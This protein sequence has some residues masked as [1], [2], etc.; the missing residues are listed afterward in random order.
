MEILKRTLKFLSRSLTLFG[1]LHTGYLAYEIPGCES[2]IDYITLDLPGATLPEEWH[3][4]LK[5]AIGPS[6]SQPPQ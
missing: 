5:R 4:A 6:P 1:R 3:W 2:K